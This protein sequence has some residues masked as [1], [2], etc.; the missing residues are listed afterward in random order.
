MRIVFSAGWV[1][2]VLMRQIRPDALNLLL[3]ANH[4]QLQKFS[5]MAMARDGG[6]WITGANGMLKISGPIRS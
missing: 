3:P 6:L 5:S 4:T 2:G 1:K